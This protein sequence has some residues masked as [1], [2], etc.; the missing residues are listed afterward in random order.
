MQAIAEAV[1]GPRL[2][3]LPSP[4]V[5]DV[6]CGTGGVMSWLHAFSP[7]VSG[8]DIAEDALHFC[9]KNGLKNLHLGSATD[10][11]FATESA[12]AITCLDVL[13]QLPGPAD[14]LQA[15]REIYRVLAPGGYALV[16]VAAY[17]WMHSAHDEALRT[18]RRYSRS[19]LVARARTAGFE[20]ERATYANMFL[21][22]L[23]ALHR[24]LLKPLKV[25]T[26]GSDV[27]PLPRPLRFLNRPFKAM[28]TLEAGLIQSGCS[29]PFGLSV[30]VLLRKPVL[31]GP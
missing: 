18:S 22:P 7:H 15:L 23:A 16:R 13:V 1:I 14:D 6:G 31:S 24:L 28:L 10:L 26:G 20:V 11:P 21:F 2:R 12:D 3:A 29:L 9:R 30:V 19:E 5:V 27:R 25:T 17:R 8:L 4:R